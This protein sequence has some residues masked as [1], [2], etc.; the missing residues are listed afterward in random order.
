MALQY[1]NTTL[2]NNMANVIGNALNG[3]EIRIKTAGGTVLATLGFSA[4][5][6]SAA[7][8]GTTT[9]NSISQEDNATA[10]TVST[11]EFYDSSNNLLFTATAGGVGSDVVFN[12]TALDAGDVV[13]INTMT[14]SA[15]N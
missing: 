7:S 8:G 4:D 15:P 14:Y 3:G 11:A 9:A 10:G 2:R 5:A 1:S 13:T 6:F 12:K